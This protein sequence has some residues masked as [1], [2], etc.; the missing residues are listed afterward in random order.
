M[1]WILLLLCCVSSHLKP[2]FATSINFALYGAADQRQCHSQN[3]KSGYRHRAWQAEIRE[4]GSAGSASVVETFRPISLRKR[5]PDPASEYVGSGTGGVR[6]SMIGMAMLSVEGHLASQGYP[7]L[8]TLLDLPLL[9]W[10]HRGI[11]EP[12]E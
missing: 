3:L 4:S 6:S 5:L 11:T 12:T 1:S 7:D 8:T 2:G 9:Y 10:E